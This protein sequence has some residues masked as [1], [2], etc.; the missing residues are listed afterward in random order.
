[1]NVA[2]ADN[3]S[4]QLASHLLYTRCEQSFMTYVLRGWAH[5]LEHGVKKITETGRGISGLERFQLCRKSSFPNRTVVPGRK[6]RPYTSQNSVSSV[7]PEPTSSGE[8]LNQSLDLLEL[9]GP[10]LEN[11]K[12]SHGYCEDQIWWCIWM[13]FI[14]HKA[15]QIHS[16]WFCYDLVIE[17]R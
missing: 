7:D 8:N 10:Y 2:Y 4:Y 11:G 13:Y 9:E 5:N 12:T 15:R 3:L 1:M 16:L 6:N 17:K 14:N